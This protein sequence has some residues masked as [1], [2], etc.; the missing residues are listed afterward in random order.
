MNADVQL[1]VQ[2]HFNM[3][4]TSC[5]ILN[6][7]ILRLIVLIRATQE[8]L[9]PCR[10]GRFTDN[11]AVTQKNTKLAVEDHFNA[12]GNMSLRKCKMQTTS[13]YKSD[14]Q[15]GHFIANNSNGSP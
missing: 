11:G 1:S 5:E 10:F 13:L 15:K 12:R 8:H 14:A 2:L 3:K 7:L 6:S 9:I 4:W